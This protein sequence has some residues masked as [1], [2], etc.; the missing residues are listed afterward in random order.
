MTKQLGM[1]LF[2]LLSWMA[3]SSQASAH[4]HVFVEA[5]IE[6]VRNEAGDFT[7]IRH[8]W[9][10]D[11]LFS[12][13]VILDYD[14]NGNNAM[15]V[16]E[17]KEISQAVKENIAEFDFYTAVR[18]GTDVVAFYEPDEIKSYYDGGQLI[19]LLALEFEKPL[20]AKSGAV[21]V[22]ASDTS[23]YVAFDFDTEN[24]T[25]SGNNKGCEINVEHPDFDKLYADN[26]LSL[27]ES[28]FNDP[29]NTG[30]FGDEFYSWAAIKCA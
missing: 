27:T 12:A 5:N 18:S 11:E 8:V 30:S 23:Y 17:L 10:F 3:L 9:R 6:M 24:V 4:P 20:K 14:A 25:V 28:F 15:D 22:S 2:A 7:E 29:S 21:R 16:D 13:T 1:G 19:M 26:A